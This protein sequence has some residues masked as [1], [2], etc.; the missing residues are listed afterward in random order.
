MTT[1][2]ERSL[3][4]QVS[5]IPEISDEL[6][7]EM[8]RT[9][10][11]VM[12]K[13]NRLGSGGSFRE[14]VTEGVDPRGVAFTWDPKLGR[15]INLTWNGSNMTRILTYHTWGYYGLFKPSLAECFAR[16]VTV[17]DD[18]KK[19]GFFMLDT[20]NMD[21]QNIIGKYQWCSCLLWGPDEDYG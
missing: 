3:Y 9:L 11:P 13:G 7:A 20:E 21:K 15:K 5:L 6:V 19:I 4:E 12:Y 18:W 10:T 14:I 8:Q 17:L 2:Y 16:F 1:A